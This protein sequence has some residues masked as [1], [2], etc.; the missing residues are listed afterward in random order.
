MGK[1]TKLVEES[2]QKMN[3]I[4]GLFKSY[5]KDIEKYN[6]EMDKKGLILSKNDMFRV[7]NK[8]FKPQNGFD[9]FLANLV[10]NAIMGS[11]YGKGMMPLSQH[12]GDIADKKGAVKINKDFT[13]FTPA[14]GE[15]RIP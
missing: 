4:F 15:T 7:A 12:L 10:Q 13:E 3:E 1:Y 8:S 2:N 5:K 6:D 14:S 9:A 11:T